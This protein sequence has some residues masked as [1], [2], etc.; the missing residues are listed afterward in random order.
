MVIDARRAKIVRVLAKASTSTRFRKSL[1][2]ITLG[3]SGRAK[4]DP[5][6]SVLDLKSATLFGSHAQANFKS[7]STLESKSC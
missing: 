5:E 3:H 1:H 6:S 4:R 7:K 2:H